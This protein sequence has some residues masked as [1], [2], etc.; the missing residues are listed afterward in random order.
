MDS[1]SSLPEE[2]FT[3]I[4]SPFEHERHSLL[5]LALVSHRFYSTTC[6]F[7][8]RNIE[9]D[10]VEDEND[11]KNVS[12]GGRKPDLTIP[13]DRLNLLQR[14]LREN[15]S[16]CAYVQSCGPVEVRICPLEDKVDKPPYP[17]WND[18]K[19]EYGAT[20]ETL[21]ILEQ[22]PNL[23]KITVA[24]QDTVDGGYVNPLFTAPAL[25]GI[26]M[27]KVENARSTVIDSLLLPT[28]QSLSLDSLCL[29]HKPT[30]THWNGK[31]STLKKLSIERYE[32]DVPIEAIQMILRMCTHLQQFRFHGGLGIEFWGYPPPEYTFST[33]GIQAAFDHVRTTLQVLDLHTRVGGLKQCKGIPINLSSFI[34]L[35]RLRIFSIMLLDM[36]AHGE[37]DKSNLYQM[38][39]PNIQHLHID[40]FCVTGVA[41][42]FWNGGDLCRQ[43][44]SSL[45]VPS[46]RL[47]WIRQFALHKPTSFPFL[48]RLKLIDDGFAEH[49]GPRR[50]VVECP[51]D[52]HMRSLFED[53]G[54][55]ITLK[56]LVW[57]DPIAP[58][59]STASEIWKAKMPQ[60][61]RH[62]QPKPRTWV[63]KTRD[64][65][66][67]WVIRVP[68]GI[69]GKW[70]LM[71]YTQPTG[72][73]ALKLEYDVDLAT[74]IR[75][76]NNVPIQNSSHRIWHETIGEALKD[77]PS[78][79]GDAE[80]SSPA[81][82]TSSASS[83]IARPA[84]GCRVA[85]S[86]SSDEESE[87][88]DF[89]YA[90]S[91][92]DDA[93]Y[94]ES[95]DEKSSNEPNAPANNRST[96]LSRHP[97]STPDVA[98][99]RRAIP[100]PASPSMAPSSTRSA[101][102]KETGTVE[103]SD[104]DIVNALTSMISERHKTLKRKREDDAN[105]RTS[106]NLDRSRNRKKKKKN[107]HRHGIR[108]GNGEDQHNQDEDSAST[109]I[110]SL[111][112]S[113]DDEDIDDNEDEDDEDIP[114]RKNKNKRRKLN[115]TIKD[116]AKKA[117]EL[118]QG[119]RKQKGYI[120]REDSTRK[121]KHR[122]RRQDQDVRQVE[123]DRT[124]WSCVCM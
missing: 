108:E 69:H 52:K 67:A 54:I 20:S 5:Q 77:T 111:I 41:W 28:I 16:L 27:M 112:D 14:S 8:F 92:E 124:S 47:K 58:T 35:K 4:I 10:L 9:L 42:N 32:R 60:R 70:K 71:G 88:D 74:S 33:K 87:E 93:E 43:H 113:S 98:Q 83:T 29:P 117:K 94:V 107:N 23:K 25:Q 40:F 75:V 26:T 118:Q 7:L 18:W 53:A 59:P 123:K 104:K 1:I 84:I 76:L 38:I 65:G 61:A 116:E 45:N 79:T 46:K 50:E 39:P 81:R 13:I 115:Q 36:E 110:I 48:T 85:Y 30:P 78:A 120:N 82:R 91:E 37:R 73:K 105:E 102:K 96:K 34:A 19:S 106:M 3:K 63:A 103:I 68:Y 6:A 11:R 114:V 72:G 100:S 86:S 64:N 121:K 44:P 101:T 22:C 57:L 51:V 119:K 24:F 55:D 49:P 31:I 2:L 109:K 80:S 99:S 122:T 21:R 89:G 66:D 56:V 15:P 95:E 97:V 12:I 17:I 62:S 90:A